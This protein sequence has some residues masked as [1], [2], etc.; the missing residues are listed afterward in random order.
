MS[1]AFDGIA[2]KAIDVQVTISNGLPAFN[3][4]GLADKSVSESKERLRSAFH[5]LGFSLPAERITVNLS[6]S[7][8]NKEGSHFDLPIALAIL[9]A[10]GLV[11]R[12]ILLN[13]VALG[14]LALDGEIK[15]INGV[16][17]ASLFALENEKGIILPKSQQIE[18]YLVQDKIEIL[19]VKN[20]LDI[21]KHFK[22]TEVVSYTPIN[23]NNSNNN[24]ND[25]KA[26]VDLASIK[27]HDMA[28]R[29]LVVAATGGHNMLMIGPPGSGKSMLANALGGILPPMNS[30][31]MLDVS[32]IYSIVGEL[33][34]KSFI[35]GRPYRSP[36]HSASLPALVGGGSK[37]KPGEIT[38]AHNGV[39]F[40]DELAEFDANKLD[41]LRQPMETGEINISRVNSHITYPAK[42]QLIGAMNPCR[43][44]YFGDLTKQCSKVPKCADAYQTKISGP[45]LD[46]MDIVIEINPVSVLDLNKPNDKKQTSKEV[47]QRILKSREIQANRYAK[48]NILTNSQAST[49]IIEAVCN[50]NND[51]KD[52][53]NQALEKFQFSTR[54]YYRII[55]TARSIADLDLVE[56]IKK[57]HIAEAIG[58]RKINYYHKNQQ[59]SYID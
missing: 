55:K 25:D 1:V 45:I 58:F 42:F 6:P 19:P 12:A 38:L 5:S 39:L 15:P 41:S 21:V 18:T 43:C 35:T 24:I 54:S 51:A 29:A 53:L 57:E 56:C 31:E 22:G 23:L 14:E 50:L 4:V 7:D 34:G 27:G 26:F 49:D 47:Q 59:K 32:L 30:K 3:I 10:M 13:Y 40:L 8:L 9:G 52:L 33:S 16:L 17:A 28:K 11:D 46:R 20:L 44:G 2:T 48:Y 37:A 36:H